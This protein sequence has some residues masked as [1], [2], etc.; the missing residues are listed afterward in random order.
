MIEKEKY[1]KINY[2]LN[3]A[4]SRN[5]NQIRYNY[6]FFSDY[7]KSFGSFFDYEKRKIDVALTGIEKVKSPK[8]KSD[9]S[10]FDTLNI[11]SQILESIDNMCDTSYK[12]EFMSLVNNGI[13]DFDFRDRSLVNP[14]VYNNSSSIQSF[15]FYRDQDELKVYNRHVDVVLTHTYDDVWTTI[16]EFFHYT[17]TQKNNGYSRPVLTEA[18]SIYFENYAIEYMIKNNICS[19]KDLSL[20]NRLFELR[21]LETNSRMMMAIGGAFVSNGSLSDDTYNY[22][23]AHKNGRTISEEEYKKYINNLYKS[24][25]KYEEEATRLENKNRFRSVEEYVINKYN[26]M[27]KRF[28]YGIGTLIAYYEMVYGNIYRM[29][30]LNREL[31][32][33]RDIDYYLDRLEFPLD[34][35]KDEFEK[36]KLYENE[37]LKFNNTDG[38]EKIDF[39]VKQIAEKFKE[40]YL[41]ESEEKKKH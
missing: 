32:F 11:C 35:I 30:S 38:I 12:D 10:I 1:E 41:S 20:F 28:N 16:H 8:P 23:K 9:L 21:K 37:K 40:Y 33:N 17:N 7:L 14:V 13:I 19:P 29:V 25:C 3:L 15:L 39:A 22:L 18:F 24:I 36:D 31:S 26:V 5:Y 27:F 4:A 6:L 34:E 2:Y